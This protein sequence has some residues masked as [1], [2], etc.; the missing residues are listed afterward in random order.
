[1]GNDNSLEDSFSGHIF[2]D[3]ANFSSETLINQMLANFDSKFT[4]QMETDLGN[5]SIRDVIKVAS[6][7]EKEVNY[8][9]HPNDTPL[10]SGIIWNRLDND[11]T[12]GI[13]ATLLY[14]NPDGEL[15]A[16][17]LA[18]DSPYNSRIHKGLP[19]TAVDNPGIATI[20]GALYPKD[21]TYWFYL[22]DPETGDTIFATTNE[23]HEANK[24]KYL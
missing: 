2:L 20:M 11:W 10:V 24:A 8:A 5:R 15:T 13:D 16:S 23:E 19:P 4:D 18:S 14:I 9:T 6:M 7:L 21:T 1:M 3:S 17:D 22:T 12:L